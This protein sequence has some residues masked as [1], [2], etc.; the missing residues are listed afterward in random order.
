[1]KLFFFL[2]EREGTQ[3]LHV[4]LDEAKVCVNYYRL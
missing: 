2:V 3:A 4:K 1:M